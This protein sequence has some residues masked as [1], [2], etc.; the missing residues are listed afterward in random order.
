[1]LF[2]AINLSPFSVKPPS[3]TQGG[4]SPVPSRGD[5]KP[6]HMSTANIKGSF[7]RRVFCKNTGRKSW[8][9]GRGHQEESASIFIAKD[10][11]GKPLAFYLSELRAHLGTTAS[12]V[13]V[14]QPSGMSLSGKWGFGGKAA[15]K[16]SLSNL[17]GAGTHKDITMRRERH[18]IS[19]E[20]GDS[21]SQ[22]DGGTLQTQP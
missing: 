15:S 10:F 11:R 22:F 8:G 7:Q 21:N 2:R 12:A 19:T 5:P 20:S 9:G 16:R 17:G 14:C 3:L 4:R 13:A 1:M 6:V 18:D